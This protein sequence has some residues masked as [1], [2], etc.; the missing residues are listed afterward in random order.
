MKK[1]L[2]ATALICVCAGAD[3]PA[4]PLAIKDWS[5][6]RARQTSEG[7]SVMEAAFRVQNSTAGPLADIQLIIT[8]KNSVGEIIKEAKPVV[9]TKLATGDATS[10]KLISPATAT[11]DY[12]ELVANFKM[13]EKFS[14]IVWMGTKE[15]P[16]PDLKL[17]HL[18]PDKADVSVLGRRL[19]PTDKEG[20]A[21][22]KVRLKNN[23]AVPAT[24][25]VLTVSFYA[26]ED[27]TA[28]PTRQWSGGIGDG[29]LGPG[30]EK[31]FQFMATNAPK[32]YVRTVMNIAFAT[33]TKG[34]MAVATSDTPVA[35]VTEP[36]PTLTPTPP[37]PIAKLNGGEFTRAA[38][39]EIAQWEFTRSPDSPTDLIVRGK[40]RNGLRDTV[41]D[42]RISLA[43][44]QL[45]EAGETK[46][47]H[48]EEISIAEPLVAGEKHSFEAK[49]RNAP[50]F[51]GYTATVQFQK[52]Q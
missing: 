26:S 11:Y 38:A 48:K 5:L 12:F 52:V 8:Y 25:L 47:V 17:D 41:R 24:E 32:D 34:P 31:G 42:V 19:N 50:E 23:G 22:G 13:G 46:V 36:A 43:L 30:E 51:S 21:L 27:R 9:V 20:Q 14:R 35:P 4:P 16:R 15:S 29:R 3:E 44:T 45:S 28:K 1:L 33:E 49:I 7:F 37:A 2:L 18:I 39:V 10:V 40:V 6:S